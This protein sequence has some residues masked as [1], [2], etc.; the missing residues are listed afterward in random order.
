MTKPYLC[1]VGTSPATREKVPL[2]DP[3]AAIWGT[4]HAFQ[5]IP[6]FAA[7]FD[8]HSEFNSEK[9]Y[10]EVLPDYFRFLG[11]LTVPLIMTH[12]WEKHPTPTA[13]LYPI[14]EHRAYFGIEFFRSTF[15]FMLGLAIMQMDR[16]D[17]P[18]RKEIRMF[19]IDMHPG[20]EYDHQLASAHFYIGWA[21]SRGIKVV[22]PEGSSLV[23]LG[24]R[25]GYDEGLTAD[26]STDERLRGLEYD[27]GSFTEQVRT[28]ELQQARAQGRL[29]EARLWIRR[30][31][32]F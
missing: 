22:I 4:G 16:E 8:V 12:K 25:Y 11:Q 6:G 5:F 15:D 31:R 3:L 23:Y 27:V 24:H 14:E 1:L 17:S 21:R 19:G 18:F 7:Y 20:E 28:K 9:D 29:E 13:L 30:G 10:A 26:T 32:R 2:H